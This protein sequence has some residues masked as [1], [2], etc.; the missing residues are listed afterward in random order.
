MSD[1]TSG[2]DRSIAT[3]R[4]GVPERE[5]P[6]GKSVEEVVES[7]A[8]LPEEYRAAYEIVAQQRQADALERTAD[9]QER[10]ARAAEV[11]AG[12]LAELAH[13]SMP[14]RNSVEATVA[15]YRAWLDVYR[16]EEER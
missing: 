15:E 16:R 5:I 11:E 14:G 2:T 9:A 8:A 13:L 12:A 3:D 4:N 6:Q 1:H 7:L 10:Q